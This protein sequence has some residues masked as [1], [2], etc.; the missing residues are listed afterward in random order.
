[1]NYPNPA[2]AYTI[3]PVSTVKGNSTFILF[4]SIGQVMMK[5]NLDGG[6]SMFELNTSPLPQGMYHYQIMEG[7]NQISHSLQVIH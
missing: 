2:D 3:I 4:N 6:I 7:Q 1:L 5:Q